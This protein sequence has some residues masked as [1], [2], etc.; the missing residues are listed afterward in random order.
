M[1]LPTFTVNVPLNNRLKRLDI[2]ALDSEERRSARQ[3]FEPG[4]NRSNSIR[5]AFASLS[6]A[7]MMILLIRL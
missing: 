7:L 2:S 6:V 1:R 5:T 4:W 3:A